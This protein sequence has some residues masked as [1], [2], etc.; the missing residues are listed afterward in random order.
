MVVRDILTDRA[1]QVALAERDHSMQTLEL[2]GP[3]E[4]FGMCVTVRSADGCLHNVDTGAGTRAPGDSILRSRSQISTEH[5]FRTVKVVGQMPYGLQH[6][7]FV[8]MWRGTNDVHPSG[9]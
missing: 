9:L 2:D 3:H 7:G 1:S 6:E 8:W 5:G 4:P